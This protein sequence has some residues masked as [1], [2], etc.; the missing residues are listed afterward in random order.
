MVCCN[1]NIS[2]PGC[3]QIWA[4]GYMPGTA[5][6]AVILLS[7]AALVITGLKVTGKLEA[8]RKRGKIWTAWHQAL[9]LIGVALLPQVK[10]PLKAGSEAPC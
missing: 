4:A 6:G 3:A 9:G 5:F 8:G 10:P 2:F 1:R 7:S